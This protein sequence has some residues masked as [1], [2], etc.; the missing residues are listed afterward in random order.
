MVNSY[1]L[2]SL[3]TYINRKPVYT[4]KNSMDNKVGFKWDYLSS[5]LHLYCHLLYRLFM[6][7]QEVIIV[8]YAIGG[9]LPKGKYILKMNNSL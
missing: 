9:N 7:L 3:N 4:I 6:H 2:P 5:L 1:N 8:G